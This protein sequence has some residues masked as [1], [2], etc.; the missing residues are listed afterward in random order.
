MKGKPIPVWKEGE[1]SY[2]FSFGFSPD[3]VPY[4]HPDDTVRPCVVVVPGGGYCMVCPPEGEIVANKFYAFGYQTFVVSYT[5]NLFMSAPLLTQP[6]RDLSRAIRLIRSRAQEFRVDPDRIILCGF[7]AGAHLCA[8]LCVHHRDCT[9]PEMNDVSPRP[10]G[11]ILSYPVITS[12]KYAHQGS[13]QALLGEDIYRR[14]DPEA[15]ELLE[16]YS[17]EKQVSESTPPCF[18]W[19]TATDE[20]VPVENSILM[21]RAL[22][23]HQIPFALHIFSSGAHGLSLADEDWSEQ[24]FGD[25]HCFDQT[26]KI[27][28]AVKSGV[29]PMEEEARNAFLGSLSMDSLPVTPP[30]PEV[31]VWPDL[32]HQWLKSVLNF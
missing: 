29:L 25:S 1:Y 22:K 26:L 28:E 30:S 31:R 4:L 15:K 21:A 10:D 27:A 14:E 17:L 9:D 3:M 11:A 24:R 12:G 23:E 19:Q 2:P 20:L 16:Y 6:M 13:F 7:S 8:S 5:T 32:A 18:L